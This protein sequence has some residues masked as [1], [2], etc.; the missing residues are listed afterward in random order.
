MKFTRDLE[1]IAVLYRFPSGARMSYRTHYFVDGVETTEGEFNEWVPYFH[2]REGTAQM[3][4][5]PRPG[6][7]M[8]AAKRYV[9]LYGGFAEPPKS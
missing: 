8:V 3:C 9:R 1:K 4:G 7:S 5:L 2:K 6:E